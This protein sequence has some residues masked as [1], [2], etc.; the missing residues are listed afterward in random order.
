[1]AAYQIC[2]NCCRLR[3]LQ[4]QHTHGCRGVSDHLP[5]TRMFIQQLVQVNKIRDIKRTSNLPMTDPFWGE[6]TGDKE[7]FHLMKSS[8]MYSVS[9]SLTALSTPTPTHRELRLPQGSAINIENRHWDSKQLTR[10]SYIFIVVQ[11]RW[12]LVIY[13]ICDNTEA[14]KVSGYTSWFLII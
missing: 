5:E 12:S 6:S 13:T 14:L 8:S 7:R 10:I 2:P 4:W 9:N 1:M 3:S 11:Y